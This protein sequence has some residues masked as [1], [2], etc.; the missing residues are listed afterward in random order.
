MA[1]WVILVEAGVSDGTLLPRIPLLAGSEICFCP[2]QIRR[3]GAAGSAPREEAYNGH[4]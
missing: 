4:G 2:R 1:A 3:W